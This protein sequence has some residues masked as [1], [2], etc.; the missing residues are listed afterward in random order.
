MRKRLFRYPIIVCLSLQALSQNTKTPGA[1][2]DLALA[3]NLYRKGDFATAAQKYSAILKA[4]P[5]LVPAQV[6]LVRSLLGV[7]KV[8]EAFAAA[9]KALSAQP[10]S[11]A[12][13]AAM[14]DVEFRRAEMSEAELNYLKAIKLDR[15]E[16]AAYVGLAHLD[17]AFCLY[18]R[19]YHALRAAH[20]LAPNDPEVQKLWL[21]TLPRRERMAAIEAYLAG[22][23][24]DGTEETQG[25]QEELQYLRATIAKPVH[26]CKLVNKVESTEII[27]EKPSAG[28]KDHDNLSVKV[29]DR[30]TRLLLDTGA[31]GIVL[32]GKAGKKSGLEKI[33]DLRVFGIGDQGSRSGYTAVANRIRVGELEFEDCVVIVL[34]KNDFPDEDGL[35]GADVFSDYLIDLDMR[36][37]KLRLSPLPKRPGEEAA[38]TALNSHDED[39]SA[40]HRGRRRPCVTLVP[41][42]VSSTPQ[43][44]PWPR[45]VTAYEE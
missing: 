37:G 28:S 14:A 33:A 8:D 25:L 10:N 26:A 38:P 34:E 19:A 15:T 40:A 20:Q 31:G 21:A 22:D 41:P 29:N 7:E 18:G 16:V 42:E 3:A 27:L 13:L 35:I 12:M 5:G 4:E 43:P 17:D 32:Y 9:S 6:G 44:R 45:R 1:D 24:P 39:R 23:H 36:A 11:A 2:A 30:N